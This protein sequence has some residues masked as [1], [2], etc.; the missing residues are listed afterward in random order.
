MTIEVLDFEETTTTQDLGFIISDRVDGQVELR[1]FYNSDLFKRTRIEALAGHFHKITEACITNDQQLISEISILSPKEQFELLVTFNDT[2]LGTP[3]QATI[4]EL[5]EEI[6]QQYPNHIALVSGSTQLTYTELQQKSDSLAYYWKQT[7]QIQ[8]A[9]FI[10]VLVGR[11]QHTIIS[12]LATLKLGAI[13]MPLEE[14][15]PTERIRIVCKLSNPKLLVT[16]SVYLGRIDSIPGVPLFEVDK[17]V[18]HQDVH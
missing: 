8:P 5:F 1:L 4:L 3:P 15:L 18:V 2:S 7:Y 11:N 12:L 16:S 10:G 6:V 17:T 9:E 13:Y 14:D